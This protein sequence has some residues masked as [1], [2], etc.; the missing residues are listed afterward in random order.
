[1]QISILMMIESKVQQAVV[2]EKREP[3]TLCGNPGPPFGV[4]YAPEGIDEWMA[5]GS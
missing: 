4:V 1:M 3:L 2:A 5:H